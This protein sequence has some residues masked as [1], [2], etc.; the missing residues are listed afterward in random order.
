MLKNIFLIGLLSFL[1]SCK[2]NS[3]VKAENKT[4]TQ[5][6]KT[7]NYTLQ[8]IEENSKGLLILFGGFGENPETIEREF[9]ILKIAQKN[10]ISVLL[11]NYSQKLWLETADKTYLAQLLQGTIKEHNLNKENLY[12]GG[13][14]SG[15]LVS[16]L[17]SD[18]IISMKQYHIDPKGVFL[19]DS[20]IDLL[21]LYRTSEKNIANNFS[22]VSVQESNWIINTLSA[23]MGEPKNG[24]T[25]YEN[26]AVYTHETDNAKN[27]S[28][29][30]NTKIRLY[31]EP[32]FKWWKEQRKA[33]PEQTNAFYIK[34][35]AKSLQQKGFKDVTYIATN[36]KGYRANG[37]RHPHSWSIIE[38]EELMHWM[39]QD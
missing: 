29:L 31:T 17:L 23:D 20:P 2:P 32:D 4:T 33:E 19:V 10:K 16:V 36:N 25:A 5:T 22:D 9:N 11:M 39:L 24:I 8:K 28:H 6:F 3:K 12:V 38:K 15:G 35:L 34:A 27:L 13:F 21:E 18:Y 1:I 30:K 14:S 37:N 26:Y 7:E